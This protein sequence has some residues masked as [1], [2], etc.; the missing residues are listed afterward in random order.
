MSS[1]DIG[2]YLDGLL[3]EIGLG[4]ERDRNML[5]YIVFPSC[6]LFFRFY[7]AIYRIMVAGC[8]FYFSVVMKNGIN[9]SMGDFNLRVL[10]PIARSYDSISINF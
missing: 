1:R 2:E 5:Q 7:L 10:G 9:V 4:N 6:Q 3:R 8:C